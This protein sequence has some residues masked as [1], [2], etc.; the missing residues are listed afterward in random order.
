MSLECYFSDKSRVCRI[1]PIFFGSRTD[2]YGKIDNLFVEREYTSLP[3]IIPTAS[4]ELAGKLLAS[5]GINPRPEFYRMTVSSI[6]N[7]MKRFLCVFAWNIDRVDLVTPECTSQ[8]LKMLRVALLEQ[9]NE[10]DL[11]SS[12]SAEGAA[13]SEA[14][15][16][17]GGSTM[18][19]SKGC[20][21]RSL[22]E[23]VAVLRETLDIDEANPGK[24]IALSLDLLSSADESLREECNKL[25]TV[26]LKARFL[27]NQVS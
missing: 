21:G 16:L 7:Q 20:I 25:N 4:L 1:F 15:A 27:A 22:K 18:S 14:P 6:V 5:N 12:T 17:L 10:G 13:D 11:C 24:V 2:A 8:V 19:P 23:C 26:L 3:D 9:G